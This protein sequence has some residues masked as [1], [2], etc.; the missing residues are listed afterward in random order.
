[1]TYDTGYLAKRI[2]YNDINTIIYAENYIPCYLRGLGLR[3]LPDLGA[4]SP[5]WRKAPSRIRNSFSKRSCKP[6]TF[7]SIE[8][9][10]IIVIRIVH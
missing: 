6:R 2:A 3:P 4:P 10:D 5:P 7:A 9:S 1:M 8:L